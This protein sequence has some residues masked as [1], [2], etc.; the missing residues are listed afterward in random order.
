MD[1]DRHGF[2]TDEIP[3][4]RASSDL[5]QQWVCRGQVRSARAPTGTCGEMRLDT[6]LKTEGM[7]EKL[8][9]G[10][11][12]LTPALSPEER[13]IHRRTSVAICLTV[14]RILSPKFKNGVEMRTTRGAHAPRRN[15]IRP[16]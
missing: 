11:T 10:M 3:R 4:G 5:L 8:D 1:T 7:A 9:E 14:A 2:G 15:Y 12:A 16:K 13:V 6:F